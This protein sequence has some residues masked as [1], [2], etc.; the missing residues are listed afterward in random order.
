[1]EMNILGHIFSVCSHPQ[2]SLTVYRA[3]SVLNNKKMPQIPHCYAPYEPKM[4]YCNLFKNKV[5]RLFHSTCRSVTK[6][7]QRLELSGIYQ[8]IKS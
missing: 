3:N 4:I 6:S 5:F 2:P 8:T 1:M 7:T